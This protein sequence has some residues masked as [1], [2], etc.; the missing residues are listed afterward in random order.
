MRT[1]QR[2]MYLSYPMSY[3]LKKRMFNP[4]VL[5][6]Q[7]CAISIALGR[8]NTPQ[9]F[10]CISMILCAIAEAVGMMNFVRIFSRLR[11][12]ASFKP[13]KKWQYSCFAPDQFLSV[14][15]SGSVWNF[16]PCSLAA[17]VAVISEA[18]HSNENGPLYGMTVS[19]NIQGCEAVNA[20]DPPPIPRV[21]RN[22]RLSIVGVV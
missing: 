21:A 6:V 2:F 18:I 16:I 17:I 11:V 3:A 1:S 5:S 22:L 12:G 7:E 8:G 9:V 14:Y 13:I 10:G 4:V 20:M 15:L 19:G